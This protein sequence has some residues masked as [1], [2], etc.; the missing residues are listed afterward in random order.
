MIIN[1]NTETDDKE[2]QLFLNNKI[3]LL[4]FDN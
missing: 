4:F 3:Y 1:L 2:K